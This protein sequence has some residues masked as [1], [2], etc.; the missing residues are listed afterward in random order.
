MHRMTSTGRTLALVLVAIGALATAAN[1]QGDKAID[2]VGHPLVGAWIVDTDTA[3]PDNPP[4]KVIIGSDGTY[5]QVDTD[6]SVAVGSWEPTGK[7]TGALTVLFHTM[8]AEGLVQAVTIRADAKVSA[9]DQN[10]TATYTLE[11]SSPDG[12]STGQVGPGTA[13]GTRI[14]VEPM[15]EPVAPLAPDE[16]P[17]ASPAA[18]PAAAS[19]GAA[20]DVTLQ[21]YAVL[22]AVDSVAAGEVPFTVT[23]AGPNDMHE[24]VIIR[25]D[26]APDALPTTPDGAVDEEGAG[27]T[28]IGEIEPFAPGQTM[29]ASFDPRARELRLRL[30]RRRGRGRRDRIPLPERHAHSLH[31]ELARTAYEGERSRRG[32]RLD[33]GLRPLSSRHWHLPGEMRSGG[34]PTPSRSRRW[35]DLRWRGTDDQSDDESVGQLDGRWI[36]LVGLAVE[37]HRDGRRGLAELADASR[38]KLDA[39]LGE[40]LAEMIVRRHGRIRYG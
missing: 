20:V 29:N 19:E 27:I 4:S 28:V 18:S 7:R 25:T 3:Q 6:G 24:F 40:E 16:D 26:L 9:D 35:L 31:G 12:T 37:V 38:V 23:N 32:R 2:P 13:T 10:L 30:Q 17:A 5:L 14:A 21:E 22:P 34:P 39:P 1:A 11:F 33:A 15:G 8:D 36:A